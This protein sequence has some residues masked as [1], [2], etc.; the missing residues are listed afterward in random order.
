MHERMKVTSLLKEIPLKAELDEL[1][2]SHPNLGVHYTVTSADGVAD[3][4]GSVGAV[5]VDMVKV[6][7]GEQREGRERGGGGSRGRRWPFFYCMSQ[8]SFARGFA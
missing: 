8:V 7:G 2:A 3:W 6:W 4:E 1:A 5:D